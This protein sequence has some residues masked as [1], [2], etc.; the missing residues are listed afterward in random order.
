MK[1][2]FTTVPESTV[3]LIGKQNWSELW[4]YTASN[5]KEFALLYEWTLSAEEMFNNAQAWNKLITRILRAIWLLL[6]FC[7]FNMIFDII[8]T[9]A[10][11]LPFLSK[12][13]GTWTWIVAL[14]LTIIV[15][16]TTIGIA[17]LYARPIV[18]IIV[19][20]CGIGLGYLIFK[21]KKSKQP[22]NDSSNPDIV[23]EAK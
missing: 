13:I 2:S 12:I 9:L 4:K 21:S 14:W 1:I 11:I 23:E 6:M 10:K 19:L 17:W 18:W 8:V 7:A 22:L 3:S 16:F 15:W 5:K 20:I